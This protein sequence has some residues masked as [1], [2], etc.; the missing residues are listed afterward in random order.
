MIKLIKSRK[1]ATCD[2]CKSAI[3]KGELYGKRIKSVGS[4]RKETV[5]YH[6]GIPSY[7]SH[8]YRYVIKLCKTC[9]ND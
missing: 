7:V 6:D 8:G 3:N 9:A 4:P 2:T 5:E 1:P